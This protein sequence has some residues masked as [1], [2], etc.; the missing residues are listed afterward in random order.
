MG[1]NEH[2]IIKLT[3]NAFNQ[4]ICF[5]THEEIIKNK[6]F[7]KKKTQKQRKKKSDVVIY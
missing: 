2:T 7:M 4:N 5:Y 3:L 6:A 1:R